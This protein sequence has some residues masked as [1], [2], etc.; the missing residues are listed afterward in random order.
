MEAED[1]R[2]RETE[3]I[4]AGNAASALRRINRKNRV[5]SKFILEDALKIIKES[6]TSKTV[7]TKEPKNVLHVEKSLF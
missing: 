7:M 6:E 5:A 3:A 4:R 1:F 2:R